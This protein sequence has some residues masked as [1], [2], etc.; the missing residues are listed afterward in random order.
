MHFWFSGFLTANCPFL[1]FPNG[2]L[3]IVD[4]VT[5]RVCLF[6]S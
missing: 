6:F 1:N 3:F 2:F 5:D 4:R